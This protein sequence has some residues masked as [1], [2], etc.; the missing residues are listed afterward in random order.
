LVRRA[1]RAT[2]YGWQRFQFHINSWSMLL[3]KMI[4][5]ECSSS[6]EMRVLLCW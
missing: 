6:G 2:L 5:A 1:V 3:G 4:A